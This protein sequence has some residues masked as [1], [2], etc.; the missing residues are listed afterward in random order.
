MAQQVDF[1]VPLRLSLGGAWDHEPMYVADID[2]R[3][4]LTVNGR[5]EPD[6]DIYI[7][8][9]DGQHHLL[10]PLVEPRMHKAVE[11]ALLTDPA[12]RA[13]LDEAENA[14]YAAMRREVKAPVT[15]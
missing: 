9:A 5:G 14:E 7:Q 10:H 8:R 13:R 12:M 6:M 2:G 15:A 3:A 4:E 11:H 1:T